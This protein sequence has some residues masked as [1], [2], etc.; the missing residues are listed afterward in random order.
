MLY[1][2]LL[3]CTKRHSV[4]LPVA[5]IFFT[6][7]MGLRTGESG[8][9]TITPVQYRFKHRCYSVN[10]LLRPGTSVVISDLPVITG[11]QFLI[12]PTSY[13]VWPTKKPGQDAEPERSRK[14][15]PETCS[16]TVTS[17]R[18]IHN[19]N[20]SYCR[21]RWNQNVSQWAHCVVMSAYTHI[22]THIHTCILPAV[23][24]SSMI[25]GWFS[26]WSCVGLIQK[27]CF[28]C[29]IWLKFLLYFCPLTGPCRPSTMTHS[30]APAWTKQCPG[31]QALG[32]SWRTLWPG[33]VRG[34]RRST[35]LSLISGG[36]WPLLG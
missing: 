29:S 36:C 30:G 16:Q 18:H 25:N 23:E 7:K 20:W 14:H 35:S 9:G 13:C 8:H 22:Y 15:Q 34:Q 32:L 10:R 1:G 17:V 28:D 27:E 4:G 24:L 12:K 19:I 31:C 2:L 6:G 3:L 11:W 33:W 26:T 21:S 5:R